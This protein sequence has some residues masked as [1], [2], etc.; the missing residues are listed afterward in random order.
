MLSRGGFGERRQRS[1]SCRDLKRIVTCSF[2]G[3]VLA[4]TSMVLS[5][6]G[7]V[8]SHIIMRLILPYSTVNVPN[9]L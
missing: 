2:F 3:K 9:M 1:V 4:T 5:F 8:G 7:K 6:F